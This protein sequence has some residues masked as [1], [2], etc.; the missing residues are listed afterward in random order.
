MLQILAEFGANLHRQTEGDS[1]M[2]PIH[3]A[4]SEGKIGS[5]RFLLDKR[6]DINAQDN[7]GSTPLIVATQHN[8]I[9]CAIFLLKN[10]ADLTLRDSNGDTAAHWAAYKGYVDFFSLYC[11]FHAQCVNED[12]TFG[13]VCV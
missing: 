13:Q 11:Y 12:D 7:T 8:Q 5:I 10:G 4:A 2:L 6:A 3:W 1:R 9:D